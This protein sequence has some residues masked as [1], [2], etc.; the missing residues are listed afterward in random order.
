MFFGKA[1]LGEN[2]KFASIQVG[3]VSI[4]RTFGSPPREELWCVSPSGLTTVRRLQVFDA[5]LSTAMT[6]AASESAM[7]ISKRSM[8]LMRTRLFR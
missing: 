1:M 6:M 5:E 8:A 4:Q 3:R 7:R 2:S